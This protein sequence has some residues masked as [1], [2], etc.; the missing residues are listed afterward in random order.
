MTDNASKS[1]FASKTL[2]G[3]LLQALGSIL[4]LF[5]VD[6][7][8]LT[9][10]IEFLAEGVSIVIGTI[11]GVVGR[12][13]ASQPI[14]VPSVVGLFTFT[15]IAGASLLFFPSCATL[16]VGDDIDRVIR[17]LSKLALYEA[18]KS[19]PALL[20]AA[21]QVLAV[22]ESQSIDLDTIDHIAQGAVSDAIVDPVHRELLKDL[23]DPY[24]EKASTKVF[25]DGKRRS[26]LVDLAIELREFIAL[27]R[28][29][30]NFSRGSK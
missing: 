17:P 18:A 3:V 2:W 19:D 11:L 1:P 13:T 6:V 8:G 15:T 14:K 7:P 10:N 30:N 24:L 20:D 25:A 21:D 9:E 27:V 26:Y 23:I 29:S 5:K 28:A 12:L 16:S 4:L 22:V